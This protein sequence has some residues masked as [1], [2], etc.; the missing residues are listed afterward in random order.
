MILVYIS[1]SSL[2]S[3]HIDSTDSFNFF[4]PSVPCGHSSCKSSSCSRRDDEYTFLQVD[5]AGM[6]M[7]TS[8][9]EN[10]AF[11][12]VLTFPVVFSIYCSSYFDGLRDVVIQL[13]FFFHDLS[14]QHAVSLC[15]SQSSF[16]FRCFVKVL[17]LQ[18]Y[19]STDTFTLKEFPFNLIKEIEFPDDV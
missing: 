19:N 3:R 12:F 13:L 5:N 14:K 2:S 4:S 9:E 16:F 10:V 11:E 1:S 6:S 17:M 8:P 18:P 7:C 15:S